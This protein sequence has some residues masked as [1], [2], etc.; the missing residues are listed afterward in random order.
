MPE[1]TVDQIIAAARAR[2]AQQSPAPA[3]LGPEAHAQLAEIIRAGLDRDERAAIAKQAVENYFAG[4]LVPGPAARDKFR[5]E[6]G[7]KLESGAMGLRALTRQCLAID[8]LSRSEIDRLSNEDAVKVALGFGPAIGFRSESL[9]TMTTGSLAEITRD[10]VNKSLLAGYNESPQT[11]RGPMRQAA[12]V[13]DF[14]DI[15]R[16]RL[17][18]VPNLP[19]WP[20][21]TKPEEASVSNEK[22][23]YAV[24]AKAEKVSFSWQLFVNDDVDALSRIPRLMGDAAARTVNATAWA[25]LLANPTMSD[26]VALFSAATGA[27]K[28]ANLITGAASPTASTLGGMQA[29]LRQMRGLNTPEGAE[30]QDILNLTPKFL[31]CPATLEATCAVLVNSTANPTSGLNSGTW[32]PAKNLQLVVEPLLDVNSITAW[33][34]FADPSRV[35]TVEVTFLRGQETPITNNWIDQETLSSCF[36]IIQTFAAKAIDWRSIIKHAGA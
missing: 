15:N 21:N 23:S 31:V 34:L 5:A 1:S 19:A 9:A 14:K 26:G 18:A 24:E 32:N 11:W 29:L 20:D 28:R 33:Y 10:A 3:K 6:V 17:G 25:Q 35:D 16:I 22:V 27:R 8:G 36:T 13:A 4:I 2:N 12:S 7:A 30:S